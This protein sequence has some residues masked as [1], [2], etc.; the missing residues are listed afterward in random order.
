MSTHTHTFTYTCMYIYIYI[1]SL[2]HSPSKTTLFFALF[3]TKNLGISPWPGLQV[4]AD[5]YH[6]RVKGSLVTS[7]TKNQKNVVIFMVYYR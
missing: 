7:P 3:S 2:Y 6:R 5:P 1:H 4:V